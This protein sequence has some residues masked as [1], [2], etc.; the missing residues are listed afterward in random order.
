MLRKLLAPLAA[1]V[2]LLGLASCST[3]QASFG[4]SAPA[5][6]VSAS[7]IVLDVRTPE[8]YASGHLEGAVLL[9]LNSGEFAEALP[10]LDPDAEYVVYCRSGSRSGQAVAMMEQRGM[11]NVIDLGSMEAAAAATGLDIVTG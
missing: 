2:L 3:A 7:T 1:A 6:T 9:N 8:E 4:D 5:V 10:G 11:A